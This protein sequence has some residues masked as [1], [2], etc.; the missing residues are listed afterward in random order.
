MDHLVAKVV[1]LGDSGVGKSSLL[2]RF[3][4]KRFSGA[5]KA[6][7]GADF[8]THDLIV[9]G[10]EVT[11]QVWERFQSLGTAFFRGADCCVLVFDVN[12]AAP[13]MAER[14]PFIVLGN[15]TDKDE[16]VILT[17]DAAAWCESHGMRY[18]ETSAK[19]GTGVEQSF[20]VIAQTAT[21]HH[22]ADNAHVARGG[23]DERITLDR[24]GNFTQPGA[25]GGCSC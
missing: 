19:D 21:K 25:E 20:D 24:K 15:K 7:I 23:V 3:T 18:F 16:R 6:T 9:D 12:V 4:D 17:K 5:Y 14:F 13:S 22:I 8:V 2:T 11:L 1:L 10:R